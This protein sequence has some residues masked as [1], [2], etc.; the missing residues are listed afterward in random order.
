MHGSGTTHMHLLS[1]SVPFSPY[2]LACLPRWIP[3]TPNPHRVDSKPTPFMPRSTGATVSQLHLV[4]YD[5]TVRHVQP[6]AYRM[7]LEFISWKSTHLRSPVKRPSR[8]PRQC[9][10]GT[11][12]GNFPAVG[13]LTSTTGFAN[14]PI[15]SLPTPTGGFTTFNPHI[16]PPG[17][18]Y[19]PAGAGASATVAGFTNAPVAPIP[20]P[21]G[22]SALTNP[23]VTPLGTTHGPAGHHSHVLAGGLANCYTLRQR[24]VRV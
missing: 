24:P 1:I 10:S 4:R 2:I 17:T 16:A 23:Y 21:T 18:A 15:A 12:V 9:L 13:A 19:A 14:A 20:A 22:G 3:W 6:T 5:P 8:R 11:A 7:L